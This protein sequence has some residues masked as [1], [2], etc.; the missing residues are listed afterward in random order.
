MSASK[1]RGTKW[2]TNI[3]GYLRE[4]GVPAAERRAL[5]G[6]QDRG[7]IAGIPGV[8]IE[9]KSATRITLAEWVAEAEQERLNDNARYGIVWAKRAGKTSPA[10]GYAIMTGAALV[11]L[12][13]EAGYIAAPSARPS[14]LAGVGAELVDDLRALIARHTSR[15][16]EAGPDHD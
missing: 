13:T 1:D 3:V 5:A 2:E 7:D 14:P 15:T 16:S 8:V 12:L 4:N 9:A 10:E 11:A 6:T